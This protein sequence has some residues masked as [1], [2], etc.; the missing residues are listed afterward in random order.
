M[1]GGNQL[2]MLGRMIFCDMNLSSSGKQSCASCHSPATGFTGPTSAINAAGAVYP[3]AAN[4][5]GN[6]RFG[7]RKPPSAAYATPS[8][9]LHYDAE[10]GLFVGGLFWDGRATGERL[11]DPAAEQA[12]GPFLNPLEQ[13]LLDAAAVVGKVCGA[14]Y[15]QMFRAVFGAATCTATN[16][17]ADYDNIGRAISAF[18]ASPMVNRYS[19][20]YDS[21]LRGAAKLTSL[22][23]KGL[24]LFKGKA[25][26]AL[27]HPAD[28]DDAGN[29][30][31]FTDNTFDNLGLPRNPRNPFY[32]MDP[33]FNPDGEGWID[34]GLGGFLGSFP[35][36][37]KY[38]ALA[39]GNHGKHRVPP[40]RNVDKRPSAGFVKAYGHNG[41][42]KSLKA[43]VHFYNTRDVLPDCEVVRNVRVGQTC[44][45]A[46]EVE[47]NL[48]VDELGNL[49]LTDHDEDALVAFLKTLSDE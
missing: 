49:G 36:G 17:A 15:G 21:Y 7:N 23:R 45:P 11:G 25:R 37:S 43:I 32:D 22:E 24:A 38:R 27:C 2:A 12:L 20:R 47:E 44:W 34:A 1:G 10:E 18:E 4:A 6:L 16:V 3:G 46:S 35:E 39:A 19:S 5:P 41:Y 33:R 14:M 26:C 48:N 31:I 30:P 9:V 40:L 8:P 29:P 13:D 42:F 28:P